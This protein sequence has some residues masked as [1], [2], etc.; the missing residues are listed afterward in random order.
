MNSK[1]IFKKHKVFINLDDNLKLR[2]YFPKLFLINS[3]WFNTHGSEFASNFDYIIP[4]K[5]NFEQENIL[6]NLEQRPQKTQNIITNSFDI[7][8]IEMNFKAILKIENLNQSNNF[9]F[10][11]IYETLKDSKKFNK[12]KNNIS[13]KKKLLET[14]IRSTTLVS[15]YSFKSIVEDF[16][17]SNRLVKNSLLM[18]K[19]SQVTRI[20]NNSWSFSSRRFFSTGKKDTVPI[21]INSIK[22]FAKPDSSILEA[23]QSAGMTMTPS[24]CSKSGNCSVCY[25]SEKEEHELKLKRVFCRTKIKKDMD[26]SVGSRS[27]NVIPIIINGIEYWVE[28]HLTILEAFRSVKIRIP[29][30]FL[31][32]FCK[33]GLR[34]KYLVTLCLTSNM[35][36][37]NG[38]D[39]Q[40][41]PYLE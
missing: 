3:F 5:T 18:Q 11:F 25:M 26:I 1:I 31:L 36:H 15:R 27:G 37:T 29:K 32:F 19:A 4:T 39:T 12:V 17:S 34:P 24:V 16:Y 22:I 7:K 40:I 14:Q 10:A 23:C 33:Y 38:L 30:K 28:S 2:K 21:Y 35:V 6:L 8:N 41:S 9:C 20:V 13:L